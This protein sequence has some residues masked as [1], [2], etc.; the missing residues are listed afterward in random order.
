MNG[1]E[2][3]TRAQERLNRQLAWTRDPA[4]A[5]AIIQTH[6]SM[7]LHIDQDGYAPRPDP[8]DLIH[9]WKEQP[10]QDRD[11]TVTCAASHA[12]GDDTPIT[13]GQA[14]HHGRPAYDRYTF[15]IHAP[16]ATLVYRYEGDDLDTQTE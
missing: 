10:W 12:G 7:R 4:Q 1:I 11:I 5:V 3:K 2:R 13:P 8:T 16:N 14:Y 9:A 15:T 6:P